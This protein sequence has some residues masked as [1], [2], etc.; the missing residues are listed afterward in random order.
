[1][2]M[3]NGKMQPASRDEKKLRRTA[4]VLVAIAVV[5]GIMI[6]S[7]YERYASNANRADRPSYVGEL[8]H[9]LPVVRQDGKRVACTG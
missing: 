2:G 5:G 8:R 3:E 9:N 1:M 7:A 4:W 6:F